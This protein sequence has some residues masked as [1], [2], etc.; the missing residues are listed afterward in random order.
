MATVKQKIREFDFVELLDPIDGWPAG[1]RGAV[2][3]EIGES[4]QIE[5]AD[6]R[7]QM[8]DLISA[9]ESRLKLLSKHGD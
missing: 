1:T 7:G 9:S 4:R 8:L 3:D 2:V 6:D 5:I